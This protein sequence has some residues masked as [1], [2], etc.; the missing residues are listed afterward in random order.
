[1]EIASTQ[2]EGIRII[3]LSGHMS[4]SEVDKLV[5]EFAKLKGQPGVRV[6]LDAT[7]LWN[8]PTAA[9]GALV[10]LLRHLENSGGRLVLAAPDANVRVPLDRLG[11]SPMLSITESLDE[12]VEMLAGGAAVAGAD[13]PGPSD[14]PDRPDEA[15]GED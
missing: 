5:A 8:L 14:P 12:A 1:M 2:R 10:E 13:R 6:I 7:V 9:V 15:A 4:A 3:R 11:V